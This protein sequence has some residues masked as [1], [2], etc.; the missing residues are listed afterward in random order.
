MTISEKGIDLICQ[1]EG[2]SSKPYLDSV[3]VPTIGFGT[4]MYNSGTKVTMNDY[5]VTLEQAKNYLVHHIENRCYHALVGLKLSQNQFDALCS[6]VY[7][8]GAGAF[9][10]STLKKRIVTGEGDI[11]AGFAMWN[12]AGGQVL[13]GLTKRR[14]A[15]ADLYLSESIV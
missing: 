11:R 13:A 2:Y 3:N 1:F 15:E 5:P 4:T 7:N 9:E 6:F 10:N 8:C 12:K 14:T